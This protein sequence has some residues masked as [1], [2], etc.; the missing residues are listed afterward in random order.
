[1]LI[2]VHIAKEEAK[3]GA[4]IEELPV[5]A[6]TDRRASRAGLGWADVYSAVCGK[7]GGSEAVLRTADGNCVMDWRNELDAG[8]LCCRWACRMTLKWPSRKARR[9][10]EWGQRCL[11][12]SPR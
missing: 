3:S 6:E 7:C 11:G 5:L 8:C 10:Y 9:K 2:E 4:E 12:T 1:M